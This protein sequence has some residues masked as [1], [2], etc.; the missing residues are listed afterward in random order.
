[1]ATQWTFVATTILILQSCLVANA[2]HIDFV[3]DGSFFSNTDSSTGLITSTQTG[4]GGNIIGGERDVSIDVLSG[5][6]FVSAGTLGAAAGAGP[7]GPD[8]SATLNFSNSVSVL[9]QFVLTYDGAGSAGLGGADFDTNWDS[10]AVDFA[11]VQGSGDLTLTVSDSSSASGALTLPVSAA[12]L[13]SFPF[14]DAAFA[15]VDFTSVDSVQFSLDSTEQASDFSISSITREAIPEP[16][17]GLLALL[18]LCPLF[19]LRS[20]RNA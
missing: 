5:T 12:G 19:A 4:D 8:P 15:G 13:V 9:G 2:N 14:S 1:M 18:A 6:G 3:V 11:A 20:K 16:T 7:V 10:L 17:T